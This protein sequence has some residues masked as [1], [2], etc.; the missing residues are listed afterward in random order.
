VIAKSGKKQC[1][2]LDSA[3]ACRYAASFIFFRGL[4]INT[5]KDGKRYKVWKL[6]D[7]KTVA[8]NHLFFSISF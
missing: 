2:S 5:I 7:S 1:H 4:G 3:S 8:G 6:A